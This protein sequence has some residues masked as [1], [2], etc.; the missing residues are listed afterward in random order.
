MDQG[1]NKPGEN[2]RKNVLRVYEVTIAGVP[3]KLRSDKDP[4]SVNKLISFVDKKVHGAL[5]ATKNGSIQN[6][7]LLALLNLADEHFELK[8]KA[9]DQLENLEK[10]TLKI[11]DD[12][13]STKLAEKSEA[14]KSQ[15]SV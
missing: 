13:E 15:P 7:A 3:L 5:P 2:Q 11:I 12:L 6:A 9:L 8:A 1:Q 14:P 4:E 10:K